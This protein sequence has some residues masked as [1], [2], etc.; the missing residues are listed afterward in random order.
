MFCDL[1]SSFSVAISLLKD[2]D[3]SIDGT[4]PGTF[5]Y[6]APEIFVNREKARVSSDMWSSG[7]TIVELFSEK[8]V[9]NAKQK[10]IQSY[11]KQLTSDIKSLPKFFRF[12]AET[13]FLYNQKIRPKIATLLTCIM[14]NNSTSVSWKNLSGNFI[15]NLIMIKNTIF[16]Y[17]LKED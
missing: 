6:M 14:K 4:I 3:T 15:K 5:S 2:L 1:L 8:P 16:F 7:C 9:W 10:L 12:T 13:F 17:Y 11:N